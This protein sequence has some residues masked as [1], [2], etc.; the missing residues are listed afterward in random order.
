MISFTRR[1]FLL[2]A[3]LFALAACK[4]DRFDVSLAT[5]DLTRAMEGGQAQAP[6]VMV[7]SSLGEMDA[8]RRENFS[9][10][11]A[12][13]RRYMVIDTF[14][15]E[16]GDDGDELVI[17]GRLPVSADAGTREPYFL[18]L[19]PSSEFEGY[20]MVEMKNGEDLA[21]MQR[22]MRDV[23]MMMVPDRY[24]PTRIILAGNGEQAIVPGAY[25]DGEAS[26][27]WTGT[28]TGTLRFN[29]RDG[30]WDDTGAYFLIGLD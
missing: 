15:I 4:A 1:L 13:M 20:T 24:Q 5:G 22:E 6:F 27:L 17:E 29:F 21:R 25:V 10:F 16:P 14:V 3:T 19:A 7:F 12:A 18:H 11:E 26:A 28:V 2:V 9:G 23:N 30:I 8:E